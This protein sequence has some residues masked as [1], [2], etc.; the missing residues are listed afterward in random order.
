MRCQEK[1]IRD[2]PKLLGQLGEGGKLM[3]VLL[4]SNLNY[5]FIHKSTQRTGFKKILIFSFYFIESKNKYQ[6]CIKLSIKNC[7]CKLMYQMVWLKEP[8]RNSIFL[9]E[10]SGNI[11][12]NGFLTSIASQK[13]F[14]P[15][16][17]KSRLEYFFCVSF[18]FRVPF[19][20]IWGP[21]LWLSCSF[22]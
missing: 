6:N 1:V 20:D 21:I 10:F 16:F 12:R 15:Y 17:Q 19:L 5:F 14:R 9:V 4:F 18:T 11:G 13:I 7:H 22:L 8:S 3:T 2:I